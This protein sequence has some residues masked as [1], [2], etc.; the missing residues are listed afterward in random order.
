MSDPTAAPHGGEST[1][2]LMARVSAWLDEQRKTPGRVVAV[3][4]A[5][6]IR[7]AIVH[8]I[9]ATSASMPRIDIAPLSVARLSGHGDRWNLV[10]LGEH[11]GG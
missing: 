9:G 3:T 10:S 1:L 7:A 6:V 5:A 11:A 8:A 2:A 4:H